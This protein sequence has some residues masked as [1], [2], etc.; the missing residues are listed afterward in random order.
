MLIFHFSA[1]EES[2]ILILFFC[3][4]CIAAPIATPKAIPS[5]TLPIATPNATPI[6]IPTPI[7]FSGFFFSIFPYLLAL[8]L[9]CFCRCEA[10]TTTNTAITTATTPPMTELLMYF[11]YL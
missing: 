10:M 8:S 2:S 7:K 1:L 9:V 5:P 11:S 3:L 6:A 4:V